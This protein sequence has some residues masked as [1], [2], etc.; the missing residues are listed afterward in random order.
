LELSA[1]SKKR[2]YDYPKALKDSDFYYDKSPP[3]ER[4]FLGN[5]LFFDKELS[6]NRNISCATCHHPLADLGDG[7]SLSVGEGAIGLG[8]TRNTGEELDSIHERVP[9]NAPALFSMGVRLFDTLFHDGRVELDPDMPSG[10]RSPAGTDLPEGLDNVLA[11]Q[12]MFPVTSA[13]EMAG[14]AGEND[15]ADA[16][17]IGDLAG[18]NGV[19]NLLAERLRA[20]PAYVELFEQA[21]EDVS[22]ESDITF[23]HAANA[24]A[25]F[26]AASWPADNTRFD[27]YLR[28]DSKAL[29]FQER[30][31]MKLFYGKAGCVD[32][33]SGPL[34]SDFNFYS[35]AMPQLG[36]G[37]GVGEYGRE[38]FG[39]ELVTLDPSDR[40][41]FRT[42]TLRNVA[43][44]A[45]Y[46]H[47]GAFNTLEGI[48]RHHLNPKY[49]LRKYD[50]A[51]FIAPYREDLLE[52]DFW[53][54]DQKE[55]VDAIAESSDLGRNRRI[56]ER[57]IDDI[58]AFLRTLTDFGTIDLRHDMPSAVPSG[59]PI[60]E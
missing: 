41:K 3:E 45:P 40:Y 50:R 53:V 59:L 4:V 31:G 37:K 13:T 51:N 52:S 22:E 8:V 14:Q 33:H 58:V 54:M 20:I 32:C 38:D 29:T 21:F 24:I 55:I 10:V 47:S 36:P 26:E 34:L 44:T 60:F 57:D 16:A 28:G 23:V 43:L 35:I 5:L 46:G 39:R 1:K 48:V 11:V 18:E 25:A 27:E 56:R 6:G 9:R 12:A 17:A 19:W 42:P 49:S 2:Y 30:R 15:I 7:L